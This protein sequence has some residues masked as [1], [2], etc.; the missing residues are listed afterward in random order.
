MQK[1]VTG[2]STNRGFTLIEL[3]IV[4]VIIGITASFAFFAFGDFGEERRILFAAEQLAHSIS[5]AQHQAILETR[6]LGLHITKT[7]YQIVPYQS[8]SGWNFKAHKGIYKTISLPSSMILNLK[9]AHKIKAGEPAI[10]IDASGDMT[11]F[12]LSFGSKT[13]PVI[14]VLTGKHNGSLSFSKGLAH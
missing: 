5:L 7:N 14:T 9:T 11:A 2:M 12:T 6:T 3:L 1:L 4:I 8:T 10:I 13:K